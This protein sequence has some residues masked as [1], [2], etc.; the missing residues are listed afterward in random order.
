LRTACD[1]TLDGEPVVTRP[2]KFSLPSC[3]ALKADLPS[4]IKAVR[5]E[6][7]FNGNADGVTTVKYEK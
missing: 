7:K 2:E 3:G 5:N 1:L 4:L 6:G